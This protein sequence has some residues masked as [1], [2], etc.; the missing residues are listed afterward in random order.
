MAGTQPRKSLQ[1]F[2]LSHGVGV[3]H[4]KD[5][6]PAATLTYNRPSGPLMVCADPCQ[7]AANAL[8]T[9]LGRRLLGE[10]EGIPRGPLGRS[11]GNLRGVLLGRC[12]VAAAGLGCEGRGLR[13]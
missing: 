7:F 13:R 5:A 10:L 8:C 2:M 1:R 4:G 6:D 11:G 12:P 9:H 3:G